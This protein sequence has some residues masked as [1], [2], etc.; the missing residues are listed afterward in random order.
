LK[1]DIV[2]LVTFLAKNVQEIPVI[3][4]QNVK[5]DFYSIKENVSQAVPQGLS[6]NFHKINVF[7]VT[8]IVKLVL[9]QASLN[10]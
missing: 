10:V 1:I 4:A 9:I 2:N 7:L 6:T 3:N 5:M 8:Q